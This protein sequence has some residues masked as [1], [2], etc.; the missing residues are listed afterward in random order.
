MVIEDFGPELVDIKGNDSIEA[1]AMSRI[2]T[3]AIELNVLEK[4]LYLHIVAIGLEK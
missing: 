1:S 4:Y 3:K 2:D